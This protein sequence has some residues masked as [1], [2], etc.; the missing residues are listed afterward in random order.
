PFGR[1]RGGENG[2]VLGIVLDQVVIKVRIEFA[3]GEL[4]GLGRI[5]GDDVIDVLGHDQ[6]IGGGGCI[7]AGHEWQGQ[8][9][10]KQSRSEELHVRFS[11]VLTIFLFFTGLGPDFATART[12]LVGWAVER[13]R[14]SVPVQSR[15]ADWAV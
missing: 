1:Q 8:R 12:G 10:R 9:S 11:L 13:K 5:D 14:A 3:S 6:R 7:G 4:I 15:R 2:G